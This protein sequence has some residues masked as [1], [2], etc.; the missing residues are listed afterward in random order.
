MLLPQVRKATADTAMVAN[1]FSCREQISQGARREARI[2]AGAAVTGVVVGGLKVWC[3]R[4]HR[5]LV[6][7][8][9]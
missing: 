9:R 7:R 3:W 2:R 5:H 8:R 6:R 4:R 1:G